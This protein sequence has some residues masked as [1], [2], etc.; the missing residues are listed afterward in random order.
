M[1][2]QDENIRDND[3]PMVQDDEPVK[4]REEDETAAEEPVSPSLEEVEEPEAAPP[5]EEAVEEENLAEQL[6]A[7]KQKYLRLMAEFDNYKR[8]TSRD[9]ERLVASANEK[10]MLEIIEVREN[11]DRALSMARE[12]ADLGKF[13][14]GMKLI[15]AKLNDVLKRNG[16]TVFTEVGDE[17]DP[18]LHDAM[19]KMPDPQVPDGHVAQIYEKGY[20]LRDRVIKHA[21]VVVSS[22]PPVGEEDEPAEKPAAGEKD[23]GQ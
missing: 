15:F 20:R 13:V 23:S 1:K 3:E 11:F 16:L 4:Q 9:Y 19:M 21:K 10:L 5:A 2:R 8:R 14:E 7:Q 22:G 18:E 6:E 17:F 12:G